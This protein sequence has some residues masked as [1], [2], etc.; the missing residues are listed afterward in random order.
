MSNVTIRSR[1][2]AISPESIL[3]QCIQL[4]RLGSLSHMLHMA[5]TT[6]PHRTQF[7]VPFLRVSE[8]MWRSAVRR[9]RIA[10]PVKT[11]AS[12]PCD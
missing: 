12:G 4:S 1:L 6:L 9:K 7:A 11:G 2:L 8:A 5:N 3:S 10:T